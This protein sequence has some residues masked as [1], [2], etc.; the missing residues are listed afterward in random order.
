MSEFIN[1]NLPFSW[2]DIDFYDE[3][4]NYD[5]S[6]DG[7]CFRE[8]YGVIPGMLLDCECDGERKRILVGHV[9]AS[10]GWCGCCNLRITYVYRYLQ[11]ILP[12]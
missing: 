3:D 11:I 5:A 12:D 7:Q 1:V 2:G 6:R 10:T 9:N 4:G 8:I